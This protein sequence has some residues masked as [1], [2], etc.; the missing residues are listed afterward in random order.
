MMFY[1]FS[2][3]IIIACIGCISLKKLFRYGDVVQI[4][5]IT[6]PKPGLGNKGLSEKQD[7]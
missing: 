5:A 4:L 6:G 1:L 3:C 7:S 2:N